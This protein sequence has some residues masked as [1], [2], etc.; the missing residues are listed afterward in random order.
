M[1]PLMALLAFSPDAHAGGSAA[2]AAPHA[3]S[4]IALVQADG[5]PLPSL[6]GK[7]VLFVNVA[8]K[9]GYTPQYEGLQSL[10]AQYKDQGFV[11]VGT[12][13]NQFAGQEPGTNAEIVSFCKL[14]YGV[15]FPILEKADVNGADRSA[16]YQWLVG[17]T[18]GEGKKIGWN[19]EKF[20]VDRSGH[21]VARFGSGTT[22]SDPALVLAVQTALAGK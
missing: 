6:A 4:D 9:C 17:S 16:L 2:P 5:T 7:V 3:L 15:D 20:L 12:P 1:L 11:I 10:Y 18:A 13:C 21:V 22:P 8:S 14:N 19:F